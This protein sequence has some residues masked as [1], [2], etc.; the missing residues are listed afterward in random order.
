MEYTVDAALVYAPTQK[1]PQ[2]VT[3][4]YIKT[5]LSDGINIEVKG[6]L[7][8]KEQ[9]RGNAITKDDSEEAKS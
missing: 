5:G 2:T 3:R 7:K 9:I 1:E 4:R 8:A 6:G